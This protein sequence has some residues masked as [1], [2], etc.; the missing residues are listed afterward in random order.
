MF[1]L[2]A[3]LNH[4]FHVSKVTFLMFDFEQVHG[5]FVVL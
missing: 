2:V 5:F 1:D 3:S 4:G